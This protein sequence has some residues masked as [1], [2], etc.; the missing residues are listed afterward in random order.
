MKTGNELEQVVYGYW[1]K[2]F[3]CTREDFVHSGTLI[4][5]EEELTGTG[6]INI[7]RIYWGVDTSK[8]PGP[9]T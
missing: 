4:I 7:Y 2:R 8:L 9:G 5:K 1:A 6:K 3:S